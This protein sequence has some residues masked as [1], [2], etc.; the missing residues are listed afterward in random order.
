M[1]LLEVFE[2]TEDIVTIPEGSTIF[3]EGAHGDCM[4]V[5]LEGTVAIT[6]RGETV[7]GAGPGQI[8][9]EMAL[10]HSDPRSATAIADTQCRLAPIDKECFTALIRHTPEFALHV[11]NELADRLRIANE[12]LAA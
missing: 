8:V 1:D 2:G 11:M 12:A 5:V 6:L 7:G 4:Y 9:G 10:I 3:E